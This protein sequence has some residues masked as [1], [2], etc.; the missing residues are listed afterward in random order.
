LVAFYLGRRATGQAERYVEGILHVDADRRTALELQSDVKNQQGRVDEALRILL[1]TLKLEPHD[2]VRRG[3][4]SRKLSA[5]ADLA[6]KS[7]D[8]PLAERL[9]RRAVVLSPANDQATL[10]LSEVFLRA[11]LR[12]AARLW[13]EAL[14]AGPSRHAEAHMILGDVARLDGDGAT[15]RR[16]YEQVGADS[17]QYTRA[18][19]QLKALP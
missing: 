6:I 2:E 11:G 7:G 16:H 1:Q 15:A 19:N 17:G 13:A 3:A 18:Q 4:V 8:F 14:L 12:D 9:L 5:E 10:R